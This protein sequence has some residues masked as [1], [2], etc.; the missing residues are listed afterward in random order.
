MPFHTLWAEADFDEAEAQ[1]VRD[2]RGREQRAALRRE[3]LDARLRVKLE[4]VE[5]LVNELV[6]RAQRDGPFAILEDYLVRTN[7]LHD[8]IAV[9]TV[10]AQRTVLA[11][12]RFMRFVADWQEAHPRETLTTSSPISTCTSRSV[13]TSTR[14]SRAGWPSTAFS[15]MTVYQAKG[16]EY[17]AVV[18][19]RLVDG[20]FPDTRDEQRLLPVELLKQKPP[21]D[22]A[23]DEERRLLFVAMTRAKRDLLLT[24]L[25]P[26]GIANPAQPVRRRAGTRRR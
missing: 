7:M 14:T 1:T 26:C 20:Q 21:A 15:S 2:R 19:P 16:L 11:V 22:F 18:V 12:A 5:E 9:E 6:P 3:Q 23:I 13:A 17:E 25:Q 10:E 24:A 8:L 4:R